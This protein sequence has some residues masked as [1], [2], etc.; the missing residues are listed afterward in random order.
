[1]LFYN[2]VLTEVRKEMKNQN[3]IIIFLVFLTI[4]LLIPT[5]CA[6]DL[7]DTADS[8]VI[9]SMD[10]TPAGV[11]LA[12]SDID[13]IDE[14]T[15][16]PLSLSMEDNATEAGKFTNNATVGC[17]YLGVIA[18]SSAEV[19]VL[20]YNPKVDVNKVLVSSEAV[21][22]G[23]QVVYHVTVENTGDVELDNIYFIEDSYDDLV[24][25][26]FAQT[27]EN[28][29]IVKLDERRYKFILNQ[30]VVPGEDFGLVLYF[31]TTSAGFK[32]NTVVAG[33]NTEINSSNATCGVEVLPRNINITLEKIKDDTDRV[34]TVGELAKFRVVI[35]NNGNIALND[36][37]FIE[38]IPDG[39]VYMTSEQ[40][41][42][43]IIS[44]VE[45]NKYKFTYNRT[46]NPNA[47]ANILLVFNSTSVG[48][49]NNTVVA[50][51]EDVELA[52]ASDF[53]N[54]TTQH[55][56]DEEG[57]NYNVTVEKHLITQGKI[58]MGHNVEFEVRVHNIGDVHIDAMDFRIDEMPSENL[59]F[60]RWDSE[61]QWVSGKDRYFILN[62]TLSVGGYATIR[63]FFLVTGE[64]PI[65][66]GVTATWN[67]GKNHTHAEYEG[68]ALPYDPSIA[69]TKTL[70]KDKVYV[71]D[72][73]IYQVVIKN[74]G[75]S[76][77]DI[78]FIE[79]KWDSVLKFDHYETED[80][81]I[82][83]KN[84]NIFRLNRSLTNGDVST[85]MLYFKAIGE[86]SVANSIEFGFDGG[87]AF[88]AISK[89]VTV[90]E[91]I[92]NMAVDKIA[93]EK[94][95]IDGNQVKF[96]FK[97]TNTGNVD[98]YNVF[99][100]E[101]NL[102]E[103]LVYDSIRSDV[104]W[105]YD[106]TTKTFTLDKLEAGDFTTVHLIFNTTSHGVKVNNATYGYNDTVVGDVV[107]NVSV[108]K[109]TP[110]AIVEKITLT[111]NTGIGSEILFTVNVTNVGDYNIRNLMI[112]ENYTAGLEFVDIEDGEFWKH[113]INSQ[114][115]D[116]FTYSRILRIGQYA[117][118]TLKFK[119]TAAGVLNNTVHVFDNDFE[120]ANA[121]NSTK[122]LH[123]TNITSETV[124]GKYGQIVNVTAN[125][126]DEEGNPVKYGKAT[127]VINGTEYSANV[128]GGKAIFEDVILPKPGNYDGNIT[129]LANEDYT[130]S[131]LIVD[132]I[133]AKLDTSVS[134]SAVVGKVGDVV[135]VTADVTDEFGSPVMNGT[136]SVE[137]CGVV[138][139][140]NVTGGVVTFEDVVLSYGG[141]FA[142][143]VEYGGNDYYNP[144]EA[145]VD[146][147]VIKYD[148]SISA[149]PVSGKVGD[150]VNVTANVTDEFGNPVMNG[151][152]SIE[153]GGVVYTANV[154]GGVVTFE[155]VALPDENVTA[156]VNYEGNDYYSPSNATVE[157]SVCKIKTN[158]TVEHV[159][160]KCGDTVSV[161]AE[162]K[163]EFGNPIAN[164]TA[165]LDI[166]GVPYT[167]NISNGI[168]TF[169]GVVLPTPGN[170]TALITYSGDDTYESSDAQVS[171]SVSKLNT[172]IE[173]DDV[174]GYHGDVLDI[175]ATVLDENGNLVLSGTA[176]LQIS[177]K[178]ADVGKAASGEYTAKVVDGKAVF[179]KVVLS[180]PGIYEGYLAYLGDE[181]Y[182]PSNNTM[183]ITVL[184]VPVDISIDATSG[185]P[186]DKVT[187]TVKVTPKDN[188]KFNGI[189]TVKFPDGTTASVN[190]V[191]G[192]G[193]TQ[194]IIPQDFK[195]GNYSISVIFDGDEYYDSGNTSGIVEVLAN[196]SDI[197]QDNKTINETGHKVV[198]QNIAKYE[199]GTPI[200]VLL[201]LLGV[202]GL[203]PLKRKN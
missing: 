161:T 139:T 68:E 136:A 4:L 18:N 129:Y 26:H 34:I 198:A 73:V 95:V 31:N 80:N 9:S 30:K 84:S 200:L 152:A 33:F 192:I 56:P 28:W 134:T 106:E 180:A 144:S 83:D 150:V 158:V 20:P 52:N 24:F 45:D 23:D 171:V 130:A 201:V 12:S 65:S 32:N 173:A 7:N 78:F 81:W 169:E 62:R 91:K 25:D 120:L 164:G 147:T 92:I 157:I 182:N 19:E 127:L 35:I 75:N 86:G 5:V 126:T 2:R 47:L 39:L 60:V 93:L 187:V 185:K 154:T 135:N 57:K 88:D 109:Q 43:W 181:T 22:V 133:V 70:I 149:D 87:N 38:N 160:G 125:I 46:L 175:V 64:G 77:L 195:S 96:E 66:N 163:D 74:T 40:N 178:I 54:V 166:N 179:E 105:T 67:N 37:Y 44:Q 123:N 89:N 189:I 48:I 199:T 15:D 196:N 103:G 145:P 124:E 111:N 119:S 202:I 137:I 104:P 8:T 110:E 59:K 184:K 79:K 107:A 10:T 183:G 102:P 186:G 55:I 85:V 122:V 188:S 174:I 193:V 49:K 14:A 172:T 146:V 94:E 197:P 69:A 114:G 165:T 51:Y 36:V 82:F 170:Y 50:G 58:Y 143:V 97:V 176:V 155:N 90:E 3:N 168:V 115:M 17:E 121:T 159:E 162:V 42:Y 112:V 27:A 13:S 128:T 190:V 29:T 117:E 167:A 142:P 72:D 53:V 16:S 194:W 113:S 61:S 108:L 63:L 140:A 191:D 148:T 138:Y 98:M 116:V 71:G 1:M 153:I 99:I 177:D 6:S 101:D 141:G 132:V 118:I 41:A 156:E 100:R 76:P 151:T 203:I 131:N 11:D 21:Y